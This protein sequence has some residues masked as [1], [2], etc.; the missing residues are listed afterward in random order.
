MM[1]PLITKIMNI[2]RGPI[3]PC[4]LNLNHSTRQKLLFLQK[5]L[6]APRLTVWCFSDMQRS[7]PS[8]LQVN[9]RPLTFGPARTPLLRPCLCKFTL[10]IYRFGLRVTCI[11]LDLCNYKPLKLRLTT[12]HKT[13]FSSNGKSMY[14]N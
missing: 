12:L 14:V 2:T 8:T 9:S 10:Y 1:E 4:I 7:S 3:F 6:T 5:T 11:L 13:Y